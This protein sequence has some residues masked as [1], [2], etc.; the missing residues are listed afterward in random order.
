MQSPNYERAQKALATLKAAMLAEIEGSER[1][2]SN[3]E[4]LKRLGLG[5]DFEGKNQNY[6]SWSLLGLLV[7]ERRVKYRGSGQRRRY[8]TR[9]DQL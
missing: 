7:G 9:D 6:L 4:L 3:A 8:F 2:L 1:A 5:S